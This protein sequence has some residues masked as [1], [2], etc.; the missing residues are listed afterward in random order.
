MKVM[1]IGGGKVGT[2]LA[3]YLVSEK[4]S[5][6][7][8]EIRAEEMESLSREIKDKSVIVIGNGTDPNVLEAAGIRT[9]DVVAVVTGNDETNLVVSNLARF[10]FS[11][12]RIIGRVNHPKNAWMFTEAMGMD[13]AINQ[14]DLIAAMVAE[15]MSMGDMV[16]LHK[17][18]KGLFNIVEE[19]VHPNSFA[20]GKTLRDL[21]L[22][23][24]CVITA[25]LRK[26]EMIIPHGDFVF[27]MADEIIAVVHNSAKQELAHIFDRPENY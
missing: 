8:V 10:E 23:K 9:M 21:N 3:S 11:V 13:V 12:P 16:T 1:I 17:L 27:E 4:H 7:L 6:K 18:R 2:Y 22:P 15:E 19:K 24:K 5:V 20:N 25:I 14:A 26:G